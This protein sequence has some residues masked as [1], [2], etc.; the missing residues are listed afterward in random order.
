MIIQSDVEGELL[1]VWSLISELSDQLQDN[2]M[3]TADLRAQADALKERPLA[4]SRASD[5]PPYRLKQCTRGLDT[6]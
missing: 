1:R 2:R 3:V 5:S 4:M 6:L